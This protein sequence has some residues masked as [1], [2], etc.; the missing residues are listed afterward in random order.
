MATSIAD[1]FVSV[2]ADVDSAIAGLSGL[3]TKLGT[4]TS[5]FQAAAPAGLALAAAGSAIGAGFL[6]SINVAADF[7]KQISGIKAVLSPDEVVKFGG[8]L[9]DL[10]LQLGKDTVFSASEAA[11]GIEELIKAGVSATD[12]MGGAAAAALNLAA[13]TGIPVSEAATLASQAMNIFGKTADDLGKPGGIVDFLAG[14]ANAS[15]ASMSDL[16][17]GLAAAGAVAAQSGLSFE[18]TATTLA[19]FANN[20]LAGSD[21]GT[22]LKT[23]LINLEPHTSATVGAF[24]QLGLLTL[25][26]S[27]AMEMLRSAGVEPVGTSIAELVQQLGTTVIGITDWNHIT[28]KQQGALNDLTLA[29][30]TNAFFDA[31]GHI[32]SMA[33][34]AGVL[35]NAL[36][37]MTD[38][39]KQATL[40]TLFGTDAMRA[41]SIVAKEGADGFNTLRTSIESISAADAA[42]L[43]MDNFKGSMQ[44]LGGSIEVVQITIGNLFLPVL[45]QVADFLTQLVNGFSSLDPTIQNVIIAFVGVTGVVA[46]LVGGF[47]LLA[48]FLATLGTSFVALGGILA[49]AAVPIAALVAAAALLYAAWQD[50][51]GGI[52]EVTAQVFDAMQPALVNIQNFVVALVNGLG[53]AFAGVQSAVAPFITALSNDLAPILA[54]LPDLVRLLGDYFNALS[55]IL[56]SVFSIIQILATGNYNGGIFGLDQNSGLVQFFISLHDAIAL[57]FDA[58]LKLLNGD[59][60]GAWDSLWNSFLTTLGAVVTA[61]PQLLGT[62]GGLLVTFLQSLPGLVAQ[63]APGMWQAFLNELGQLPG[64][65]QPYW[66]AFLGWLG[67]VLVQVPG[68][69]AAAAGDL[70]GALVQAFGDLVPLLAPAWDVFAGWLNSVVGGIPQFVADAAGDIWAA[71]RA[72][73]EGLVDMLSPAWDA[74]AGWLGS[75]LGGIPQFVGDAAGDIWA[76]LRAAFEG[77]VD[78]LA[79]AWDVF[80]GWLGSILG[81]IAQFVADNIGDIWGPLSAA[82]GGL[83]DLLSP[84][85]DAFAGWFTAILQGLPQFVIDNVGDVFGGI[86]QQATD[87]VTR[88]GSAIDP[89]RELLG[90]TFGNIGNWIGSGGTGTT[91]GGITPPATGGTGTSSGPIVS[92]G[93]II[94]SSQ[95]DANAFLQLVADAVLASARR[96]S[97]PPPGTIPALS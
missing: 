2:T 39:Q 85:W 58:V 66:D 30:S 79:P 77:L 41:A 27:K 63:Y 82:F 53:P 52:Q 87:L 16:K 22:S 81:G 37:G 5:S 24:Q 93:T 61:A 26:T 43:R 86:V 6:D 54:R 7:Q 55:P 38:E 11:N 64:Q 97:A 83:V 3:E 35:Q 32:K 76:A 72:A 68:F 56:Q 20:G 28:T 60:Q 34:V 65:L 57:F 88:I 90:S 14:A 84:L 21:A 1:L 18:D 4:T 13:S 15:A 44:Q 25:D 74:F 78:A 9:S 91:T 17:F 29:L 50:D 12:V 62:I 23:M 67:S 45:K 96:V 94:I 59:F 47:V 73:F 46:S 69:I 8:A 89:I 75:V 51:F 95:D 33:D 80:A 71:L 42:A 10:A 48:P 40:Y 31:A 92:V 70:W 49:A 36:S 19:I